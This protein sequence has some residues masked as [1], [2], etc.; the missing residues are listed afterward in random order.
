M[1]KHILLGLYLTNSRVHFA[2]CLLHSQAIVLLIVLN[3]ENPS[4]L[5]SQ[6][7]L[8]FLNLVSLMLNHIFKLL[9][10]V[11]HV[12]DTT[13]IARFRITFERQNLDIFCRLNC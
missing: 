9:N 13:V 6:Q 11:H 2:N 7:F 10:L 1:L 12:L 5:Q 8:H 4:L 3:L